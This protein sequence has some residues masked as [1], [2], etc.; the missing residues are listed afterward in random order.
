MSFRADLHCHTTASDGTLTPEELLHLAVEVGL[1]GLSITDHDT[2]EAYEVATPLARELGLELL[3]GIELSSLHGGASVHILGYGY[4]L[5]SPV[6]RGLC[7]WHVQRRQGRNREILAL[8]AEKGMPVT[9]EEMEFTKGPGKRIYGRPH[10]AQ[11]MI[12]KG[13]VGSIKEAFDRWIGEGRPCYAPG[14]RITAEETIEKIHAAGGKAVIAHPHLIPSAGL[15]RE[16]LELPFDGIEGYYAKMGPDQER[17]W[18]E[19]GR[20]KGWLVTGGS[21][22]HGSSKPHIPLGCSW[23]D[24]ETFRRVAQ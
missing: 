18:V 17:V 22:F 21:D 4:D 10:I 13:Y 9:E 7:D 6:L 12:G 2:I 20:K 1:S 5:N 19:I 14:L 16:L 23:V 15:V 11:A 3:P 8:L 24:E